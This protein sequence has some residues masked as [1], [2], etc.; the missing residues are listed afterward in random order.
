MRDTDIL[1]N[2]FEMNPETIGDYLDWMKPN[3]G[4]GG[5]NF[6]VLYGHFESLNVYYS[7]KRNFPEVSKHPDYNSIIENIN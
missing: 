3:L 6:V 4:C 1:L 7:L 5:V 2:T